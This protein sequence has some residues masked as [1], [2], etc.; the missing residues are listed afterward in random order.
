MAR[1]GAERNHLA[2]RFVEDGAADGVLLAKE[3]I[4]QCGGGRDRVVVFGHRAAAVFHAGRDIDQQAAAEV[5]VFFVLLDVEAVL[6]GPDLP[7]DAAQVVARRVFAV[8][9]ELDGLAEVRA[10]VHAAEEAFDDVSSANLQPADPLDHL[11]M[12]RSFGS[13]RHGSVGLRAWEL[14]QAGGR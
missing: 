11:R 2:D 12:Q 9:E 8:L 10:A 14:F 4:G 5:R 3:Q 13:G 1:A 6:L 7:I